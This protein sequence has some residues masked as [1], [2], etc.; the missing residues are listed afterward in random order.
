MGLDLIA[1]TDHNS[2]R[3][4]VALAELCRDQSSIHCLYGIEINTREEIHTLA[5]FDDLSVILDLDTWVYQHL[6]DVKNQADIFGYQ[7]V[8]DTEE[9]ILDQ[10]EKS[11]ISAIDVSLT[12]LVRKVHDMGGLVIP[13]HIDRPSYSLTS[14]L[15]FIPEDD[16]DALELTSHGYQDYKDIGRIKSYPIITGSDA[17]SLEMVG[18]NPFHYDSPIDSISKLYQYLNR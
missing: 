1:L 6:P 4:N 17:H 5:Y 2:A 12:D 11:L 9:N 13:A 15:G 8:V 14:Q 16:F 7:V 10:L 3:N 18:S